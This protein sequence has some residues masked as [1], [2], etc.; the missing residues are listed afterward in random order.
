[1]KI[2]P[3]RWHLS[4][5]VNKSLVNLIK[6]LVVEKLGLKHDRDGDK[7]LNR[8]IYFDIWL[9]ISSSKTL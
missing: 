3:V 6:A 4:K 5:E 2:S 1:M 7:I 9:K 8:L